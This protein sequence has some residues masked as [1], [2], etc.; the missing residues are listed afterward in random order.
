MPNDIEEIKR[1][2]DLVDLISSYVTL[3]KAGKDFKAICPFH[4]EKTPS[5]FVSPEKQIWKCFGCGRGGDQFDFVMEIEGLQFGDALQ[6][7]ANRAGV[8][9]EPRTRVDREQPGLKTRLFALNVFAAKALHQ[10]LM[11]HPAGK[12]A[13]DYLKSRGV[14]DE[15][16]KEFQIGFAP[17]QATLAS[18]LKK[19]NFTDQESEAAGHPDKFF[20]RTIF[21]IHDPVGNVI[22]FTGRVLDPNDQ[23]KYLNTPETVIFRKSRALYGLYQGKKA[24]RDED[25]AILVE[26]QMDVIMSHQAG[27]KNAVATSGTS[28]TSEHLQTLFRYTPNVT[29]AFDTDKAGDAATRRAVEMALTQGFSV[30]V[31]ALPA[32][33]PADL[34]KE[35]PGKWV[36]AV[37]AAKELMAWAIERAV[38][39]FPTLTG[40]AKRSVAKEILPLLS[41]I[42]DPIEQEHWVKELASRLSVSEKTILLALSKI[43]K[44]A[45]KA[46]PE[47]VKTPRLSPEETL[48]S[49][50]LQ[51]PDLY[52][53][54]VTDLP[55]L[56]FKN[57]RDAALYRALRDWYTLSQ[58]QKEGKEFQKT[59]PFDLQRRAGELTFQAQR[60][61]SSDI[62]PEAEAK[63]LIARLGSDKNEALKH[64]F[65]I[66]IAEAEKRGDREEV[67]KLMKEFQ[68]LL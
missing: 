21:P 14:S 53:K 59:V 5:F 57:T 66:K 30:R 68:T 3:K 33:D 62:D 44:P 61:I 48:L 40:E 8:K 10:I 38:G 39:K 18:L 63:M 45:E 34:V 47:P 51:N 11:T 13:K 64:E 7:L 16:I 12:A 37:S 6:L 1:R 55:D 25:R 36:D 52:P 60:L 28:L 22:G 24:I 41:A 56:S 29:F 58:K 32:K 31:A 46:T 65:A 20:K 49:L 19:Y 2:V 15:T 4:Q 54:L 26:G 27:V 23:P 50:F 42:L 35:N 9:L 17:T 43:K 67:Q